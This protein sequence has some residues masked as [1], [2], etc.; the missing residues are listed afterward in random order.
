MSTVEFIGDLGVNRGVWEYIRG[1]VYGEVVG[2]LRG[3][4]EEVVGVAGI[5]FVCVFEVKD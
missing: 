2:R 1:L 3:R 5:C 4:R